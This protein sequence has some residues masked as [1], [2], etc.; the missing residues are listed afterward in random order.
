[1]KILYLSCHA[2]LEYEEVKMFHEL[3]HDVFSLNGSYQNPEN[4]AEIDKRPGI[5]GFKPDQHLLDLAMQ[6]S[7]ANIHEGLLE[8]A[9]VVIIMHKVDWIGS[10]K[11]WLK[12]LLPRCKKYNTKVVWRTIGQSHEHW[13]NIV[14]QFSDLKIVRYSPM[15][16]NIPGFAGENELIRF[17][18]DPEEYTG[19]T[20]GDNRV[21]VFGQSI[22]ER[23]EFC[24]FPTIEIVTNGF[25]RV[26]YGSKNSPQEAKNPEYAIDWASGALS[27]EEL[28]NKFRTADVAF[29]TGTIP[30]SYT[31]SF[32]EMMMTGTPL[33][34]IGRTLFNNEKFFRD[35]NLYEIPNIIKNGYN[36]FVSDSI[37]E[38]K[39]YLSNLLKDE[40][41]R[42]KISAGARETALNLFN[43][44]KIKV[45]WEEFLKKL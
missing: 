14:R 17:G 44:N 31:L 22:K 37:I 12:D 26:C 39:E 4:P 27:F 43:K 36:G 41:L 45:Q 35:H 19:W 3:G 9:D 34:C 32:I 40:D 13:E 20:G 29:Y 11:E 16:K 24:G 15:E 33:V 7:R 10:G 38:L 42:K 6:S 23:N 25:N 21:F 18:V 5:N 8:W 1:M 28:K 30:A 2:I